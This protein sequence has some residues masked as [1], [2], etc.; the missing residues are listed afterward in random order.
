VHHGEGHQSLH[1]ER[2]LVQLTLQR[3]EAAAHIPLP[4]AE[5][6]RYQYVFSLSSNRAAVS[7]ASLPVILTSMGSGIG[8]SFRAT[9][10]WNERKFLSLCVVLS[11]AGKARYYS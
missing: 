1:Y 8:I 6:R 11:R 10:G 3:F 4:P 5:K 2:A 7:N 9:L